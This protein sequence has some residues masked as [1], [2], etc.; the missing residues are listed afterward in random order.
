VTDAPKRRGRPPLATSRTA[1]QRKAASR[2]V[3][4]VQAVEL[5]GAVLARLDARAA[6]QGDP[7]RAALI[8]RLERDAPG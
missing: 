6:R 1:T 8:D 5:P 3:R 7:S 4:Q 2:A